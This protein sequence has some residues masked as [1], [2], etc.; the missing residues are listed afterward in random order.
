MR[1]DFAEAVE[2][3][4]EDGNIVVPDIVPDDGKEE[5]EEKKQKPVQNR[6]VEKKR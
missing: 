4:L 1:Q 5:Q 2:Q 3:K 6:V